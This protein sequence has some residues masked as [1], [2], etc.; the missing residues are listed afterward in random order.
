MKA[1]LR[2]T[3]LT[4]TRAL[5]ATQ[6]AEAKSTIAR[7]L[8]EFIDTD[9]ANHKARGVAIFRSFKDEINLELFEQEVAHRQIP[10][11][12][13][14]EANLLRGEPSLMIVPGVAFDR[15]GHRLGR[16]RGYYDRLL[17][18]MSGLSVPCVTIGVGYD[19]Q[20][21]DSVPVEPHDESLNYICTPSFGLVAVKKWISHD[22]D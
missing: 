16:G 15:M 17:A 19:H 2:A 1:A 8:L 13:L 9:L 11:Q 5:N 22:D 10:Y 12:I 7:L 6:R 20:L 18:R 14:T 21:V 4:Q 3:I